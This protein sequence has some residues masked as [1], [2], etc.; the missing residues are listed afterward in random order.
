MFAEKERIARESKAHLDKIKILEERL[1]SLMVPEDKV[2][3]LE[4]DNVFLREKLKVSEEK[5]K[6]EI[7]ANLDLFSDAHLRLCSSYLIVRQVKN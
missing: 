6:K 4:A 3:K 5:R 7:D 1:A 2:R